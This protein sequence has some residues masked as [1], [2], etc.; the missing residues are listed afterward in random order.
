MAEFCRSVIKTEDPLL[1]HCSADVVLAFR[2]DTFIYLYDDARASE[3]VIGVLQQWFAA[4]FTWTAEPLA[5][6]FF[7]YTRNVHRAL[8]K[9]IYRICGMVRLEW[10]KKE[11]FLIDWNDLHLG[12]LK[13]CPSGLLLFLMIVIFLLQFL[14]THRRSSLISPLMSKK[15]IKRIG[16]EQM[17]NRCGKV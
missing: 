16:L 14:L 6:R 10:S 12:H 9:V 7:A 17:L 5:D 2:D 8:K 4:F 3:N 13:K 11:P 15:L 1:I